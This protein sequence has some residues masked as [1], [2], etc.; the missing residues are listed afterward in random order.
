MHQFAVD[1]DHNLWK[2]LCAILRVPVDGCG[3]PARNT[4]TLPLSLGGLGLRSA[5]R[6]SVAAYW[7]SWAD[8][9]PMIQ[10]RHPAVADQIVHRLE[11]FP[12]SPCLGSASGAAGSLDGVRGWEVP[13]WSDLAAGLR[14]QIREPDT[15]EPECSRQGWQHEAASRVEEEFRDSLFPELSPSRQA[16]L[17]SQSGPGAGAAFSVT[18]SSMLTRIEPPLFRVLLQRRLHLPLPLSKR[19]CGCGHPL[20]PYGHHRAACGRTGALGRRG[21]PL[22]SAAARIC[23]EGGARVVP[24]MLVRDMDLEVPVAADARRLEVVADGLPLWGGVQLAVDATL[25]S[26]LRGDGNPRRGA[27]TRDGVALTEARRAKERTYPEL[28]G[29]GSR[30]RLGGSGPGSGRPVVFRGH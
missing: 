5:Q 1:H 14:P 25:V 21:F 15:H 23:R 9:L 18:P 3:E 20:D 28:V 27:A 8:A 24:N 29:P 7:A 6:S 19:I 17:R 26:A 16:L 2:C 11:G 22:E 12:D 13:S 30:A 10:E 4:A